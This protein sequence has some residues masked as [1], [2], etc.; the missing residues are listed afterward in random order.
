MGPDS[1]SLSLSLVIQLANTL[2]LSPD[3]FSLGGAAFN[4]S[5]VCTV[6][7][8]E[9]KRV[10]RFVFLLLANGCWSG[11]R[12]CGARPCRRAVVFPHPRVA[13]R[14][15]FERQIASATETLHPIIAAAESRPALCER[16][17]YSNSPL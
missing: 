15:P 1:L 16:S 6:R 14:V 4:S 2:T 8:E 9:G 10:G 13:V 5:C 11:T 3:H 7:D 12:F 17:G